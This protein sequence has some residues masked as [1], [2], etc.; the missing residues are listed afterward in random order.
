MN[1]GSECPSYEERGE[2]A[3]LLLAVGHYDEAEQ[4]YLSIYQDMQRGGPI[5]M[6]LA[7]KIAL[8]VLI[9]RIERGALADAHRLWTARASDE[10]GEGIWGIERGA[11]TRPDMLTYQMAA[12]FL[13][14]LATDD[15]DAATEAV[16]AHMQAVCDAA[17]QHDSALLPVAVKNW[18]QILMNL[19][20]AD[21]T[22]AAA[23][24]VA[25]EEARL[26]EPPVLD[27][28]DF[29]PLMPWTRPPTRKTSA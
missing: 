4:T 8:G 3:D 13:H 5:D 21:P 9:T 23:A 12:A 19:H 14:S 27:G 20:G 24:A 17:R 15:R 22:P 2:A 10:L 16:N 7:A 29:P 28:V 18:R 1:T 11:L 26:K 25:A 6:F